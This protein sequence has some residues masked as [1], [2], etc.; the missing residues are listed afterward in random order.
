[1]KQIPNKK[2]EKK[3]NKTTT[4]TTENKNKNKK[5]N[6]SMRDT[7]KLNPKRD[8]SIKSELREP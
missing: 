7:E 2:L 3:Q 5:K 1:M 4:K 8:A 6:T